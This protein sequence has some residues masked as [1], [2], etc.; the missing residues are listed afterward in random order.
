MAR[1]AEIVLVD[2]DPAWPGVYAGLAERICRAL[3]DRV[4]ELEHVGSTSIP[5]LAAKPK[6]D[7]VLVV[8]D[9][10]DE[11]SYRPALE[12]AGFDFRLREPDWHEHRLFRR[13]DVETNLHVFSTGSP[14]I[15][16]MRAFRDRLRTNKEERGRYESA[17]RSLAQRDWP[18]VQDYADAKTEV[19]EAIIARALSASTSDSAAY[20]A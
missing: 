11:P 1:V 16:R 8:A 18:T 5:G 6:I 17:K 15:E 3:G 19:V 4:V 2:Y 20:D 13:H 9:A 7:I 12:Q 10:A 14:E